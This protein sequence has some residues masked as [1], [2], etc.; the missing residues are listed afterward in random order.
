M[1]VRGIAVAGVFLM[2]CAVGGVSSQL[3]IPKVSAQQAA[4]LTKWEYACDS[5]DNTEETPMQLANRFGAAGYELAT[6]R[7]GGSQPGHT[8]D[9]YC[10]KRPKL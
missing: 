10:F 1:H 5:P 6:V 3:A 4:T 2:G 8:W 7:S 9:I